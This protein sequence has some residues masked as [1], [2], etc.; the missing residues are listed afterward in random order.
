M[1]ENDNRR[2]IGLYIIKVEGDFDALFNSSFFGEKKRCFKSNLQKKK[3][4]H[5]NYST[6]SSAIPKTIS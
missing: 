4:R 6:S 2:E 1:Q 3:T 5:K